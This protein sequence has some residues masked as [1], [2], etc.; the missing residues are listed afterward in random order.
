MR[1]VTAWSAAPRAEA[2]HAAGR[3]AA[4][5]SQVGRGRGRGSDADAELVPRDRSAARQR[6]GSASES[7]P[8]PDPWTQQR[9]ALGHLGN[10]D[11]T[12]GQ[13]DP[14]RRAGEETGQLY[15]GLFRRGAGGAEMARRANA[16]VTDGLL[17]GPRGLLS[18]EQRAPLPALGSRT[19]PGAALV[20]SESYEDSG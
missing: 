20:L 7:R 6:R 5:R 14:G 18:P 1:D 13:V 16:R 11:R 9:G 12:N 4:P 19:C 8:E 3:R 17:Q 10:S 2:L 15:A